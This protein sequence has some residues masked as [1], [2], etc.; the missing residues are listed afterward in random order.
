MPRS[1]RRTSL[2]N[3]DTLADIL[4]RVLETG[5]VVAGDIRVNLNDVELLTIQI[6]LII[7]SVDKAQEM[8]MD[9]WRHADYL[10]ANHGRLSSNDPEAS[11][12]RA[13]TAQRLE[14]LDDRMQRLES[15]IAR[16][17]DALDQDRT[18]DTDPPDPEKR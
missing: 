7:C 15:Q 3:S 8:G 12:P 10:T 14:S 18:D 2:A 6:R 11:P 13:E 4:E 5:I 9:W 16:L 17:S 1:S